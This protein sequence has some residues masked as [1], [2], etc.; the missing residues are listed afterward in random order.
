M[1]QALDPPIDAAKLL[2]LRLFYAQPPGNSRTDDGSPGNCIP[3]RHMFPTIQVLN[4]HQSMEIDIMLNIIRRFSLLTI[5]GAL[6]AAASNAGASNIYSA[7]VSET[8][9]VAATKPGYWACPATYR[10]CP[11]DAPT[12]TARTDHEG[13]RTDATVW[14]P[15]EH[16]TVPLSESRYYDYSP[17]ILGD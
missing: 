10:A 5:S 12:I 9:E 13:T 17:M 16:T 15:A 8:D 1:V 6:L 7:A 3:S 2:F 4:R 14:D 11:S